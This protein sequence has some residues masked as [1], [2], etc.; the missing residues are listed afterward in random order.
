MSTETE[1]QGGGAPKLKLGAL[2][3]L[4]VG[5]MI[6]GGI[7]S[8]PQNMA[9]GAG[10]G[11]IL[12]GWAITF[13]GM[14]MLAF[15]F[16]MLANRK[17][18]VEGGVYGYARAGFGQYMGFNSAWGYWISAWIGNV[19]YFVVMFSALSLFVPAFGE[20]NTPVAI[21]C[22]SVLLWA[23]HFLVLRG[24]HGA[25]FI[26]TVTTVAKLVPLALFIVLIVFAFNIDTFN[27]DF[28]GSANLG[29]VI[30]QVKS[31]M[32][33]TVWVFIGIEGAS[34]FSSRAS[35]MQEVGKATVL[36][37]LLTIALLVAVSVLSLGVMTQP[38]LAAL[39]NPSTAYVLEKAVGPW[40]AKLMNIGLVIS[41]G[42]ALLA[43]TLLAAEVPYLAGKDGTMPAIFGKTNENGAPTFALWLTNG[44]IQLFL[45]ITLFSS[46]G[47]LALLS[48]ATS[49]ILI[50]YLLCAGYA[51]L[52]A[53]R[54][55]GYAQG[56]SKARDLI[57]AVV[58]TVYGAW[59]IYAAGPKYL[60]LSMVLY[61]PGV[62]FYLWAR[63]ERGEKMFKGIEA[64]LAAVVVVLGAIAAWQLATGALSL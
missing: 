51:L 42:G 15:V 50:P 32:L 20:G 13:V 35:S 3:A 49:M 59:L 57:V 45:I 29:S 4:V 11:A 21:I 58:A 41:V 64:A 17:P 24:V 5:S 48:L 16:Q 33:V 54:G 56:E 19:S 40:G 25:A 61:A 1:V 6:G 27:L 8:L 55:E 43:W 46:A 52:V 7:F 31:T 18:E 53:Q 60:Y 28:W 39:K 36:G 62:L 44:L 26:N 22:A 12:I 30:D 2:T 47:Y 14:L 63:K 34:V 23:L 10:A 9:A 37:F 38:E